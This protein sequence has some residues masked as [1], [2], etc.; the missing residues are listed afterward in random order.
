[1]LA[2]RPNFGWSEAGEL[3]QVTLDGLMNGLVVD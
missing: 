1:M 3:I 2:A